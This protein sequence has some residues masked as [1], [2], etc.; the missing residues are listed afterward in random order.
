[1]DSNKI[2]QASTTVLLK[3]GTESSWPSEVLL[4]K[5]SASAKFLPNAHVF[6]GGRVNES[7][8][9]LANILVK[10]HFNMSRIA[11]GFAS[12][13]K[14]ASMH[15]AA[16]IR[17]TH[18][19]SGVSLIKDATDYLDAANF[20]NVP[21]LENIWPL[22]WWITPEGE[23]QR[24]DTWFFLALVDQEQSFPPSGEVLKHQWIKP[25]D[26]LSA[27]KKQDIYFWHLP[28]GPFLSA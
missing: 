22:S 5:R 3:I 24:F 11:T 2:H 25:K 7:D 8:L 13:I 27:H 19:E 26:A 10:D 17:E 23:A 28:P 21:N 6:P 4:V 9:S 18:G 1:M 12:D 14:T 16:A 15:A 20:L